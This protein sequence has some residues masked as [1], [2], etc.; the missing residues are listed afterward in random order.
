VRLRR[1]EL[2]S[3]RFIKF[4][5]C[6]CNWVRLYLWA[7]RVTEPARQRWGVPAPPASA[8]ASIVTE[9]ADANKVLT[10]IVDRTL[11]T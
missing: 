1:R 4:T 2:P 7:S 10:S 11:S 6:D 3:S 5:R 9:H 8:M